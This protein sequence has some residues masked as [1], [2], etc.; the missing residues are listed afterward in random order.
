MLEK[1]IPERVKIYTRGAAK[2]T[3]GETHNQS[4]NQNQS[5]PVY[6]ADDGKTQRVDH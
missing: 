5:I 2:T 4:I 1:Q 3:E 6:F